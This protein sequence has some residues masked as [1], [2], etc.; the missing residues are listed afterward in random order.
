VAEYR[1]I[2]FL[3]E[4]KEKALFL[5][6]RGATL[7]NN[8]IIVGNNCVTEFINDIIDFNKLKKVKERVNILNL[9]HNCVFKRIHHKL[10]V[11]TNRKILE[12]EKLYVNYEENY[13]NTK[14]NEESNSINLV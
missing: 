5:N 8:S 6:N 3:S 1:K 7:N 2:V 4:F 11:L 12:G 13:W 10:F 14:I 9:N